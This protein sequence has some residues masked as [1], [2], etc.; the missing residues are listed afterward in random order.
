MKYFGE[1]LKYGFPY[2]WRLI[3][4]VMSNLI[5]TV[6]TVASF[7]MAIPFL[8]ILFGKQEIVTESVPFALTKDAV[9]HNL[10]YFLSQIIIENGHHAALLAV[11]IIVVTSIFLKSVFHYL[12][13]YFFVPLRTGM[14]KDIRNDIYSKIIYLPMK[15]FSDERKGDLM[16][17]M[18]GDVK[19]LEGSLINS[20]QKAIRSPI[21]LILFLVVL[22]MMSSQLTIIVILLLPVSAILIGRVAKNLRKTAKKGQKRLGGILINVEESL[23][24]IRIIKAFGAE[25]KAKQRFFKDNKNYAKITNRVLWKKFL[26]HP[27]SETMGSFIIVL[28]MWYGGGM[29][30][31]NSSDLSAETFITFIMIFLQIL[32]PAKSL[33]NLYF[34]I[35]K[36]LAS[37]ERIRE[38]L[39][40]EESI[41]NIEGAEKITDFKEAIEYKNVTFKYNNQTEVLKDINLKIFK[42]QTVALV[43]QSGA[44]KSTLA[45][46]LP[47]FYDIEN[48]EI[49]IDNKNVKSLQL[50]P[51]RKL[52]GIVSQEQILFNDTIFNNIAFGV[53]SATLEEVMQAAK[54]ANAHEFIT[55][56]E[57]GYETNI[58]D[59]G[60]K[61]SGGQRQRLTIARAILVNPPILILDEATSALDVESEKLV[62]EAL[63]HLM[64]NRTSI[65][66]AHRL[67]TVKNADLVCVMRDGKIIESGKHNDLLEKGGAFKELYEQQMS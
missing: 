47:R 15:F 25:E 14:I 42:G 66:I 62:Q 54:V 50:Q 49:L 35:N 67:S 38:I 3:L 16:S 44:G 64:K 17:R 46:L 22:F 30:L 32:T 53:E 31:D 19:E 18:I 37:F 11:S 9:V 28:V 59:R 29:V 52:I 51:M 55:Q 6:F 33:S 21:E 48:G 45:D 43:G 1:F 4:S 39:K 36:G 40:A 63:D 41:R 26:A 57:N 5:A 56:T 2:K 13:N 34:D 23:F 24:G 60:S 7:S 61:L 27:I 12:G 8:G 20:L 10:N 65:V 58:G